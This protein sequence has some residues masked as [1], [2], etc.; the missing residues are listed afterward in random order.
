MR[1]FNNSLGVPQWDVTHVLGKD[2][3]QDEYDD[4][5]AQHGWLEDD[6]QHPAIR[7]W[8]YKNDVLTSKQLEFGEAR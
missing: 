2:D 6:R 5:Q 1:N 4:Y 8:R 7:F 3:V